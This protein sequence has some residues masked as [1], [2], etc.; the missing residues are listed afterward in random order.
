MSDRPLH[1]GAGLTPA[2]MDLLVVRAGLTLNP[3]Q[4]ADLVLIWRQMAALIAALPRERPLADDAAL[5]FRQS[6]PPA[7]R[8]GATRNGAPGRG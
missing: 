4:T 3:G 5:A 7:A 1:H 6:L 8:N 2:E